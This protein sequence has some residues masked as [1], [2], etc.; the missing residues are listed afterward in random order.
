MLP[1]DN[2]SCDPEQEYFADGIVEDITMALSRFRWLF[3]IARNSS[4]TYKGRAVDVKQ[5]GRELGVRYVL[6]GSVR[7]AGNRMRIAGQ[8]IDAETGA[9]L[10]ADRFDG[11]LED[12]FDLQDH[13]TS[14]V[15][16]AIA[17]KLQRE[18][19]KRAKRK[20]TENLD[21]YDYYLRGLAS[22]RRWTKDANAEA[23]R[24]FC[25]A[26]EL[27]PGL[28]CAYGMAAWCYVRRKARGWMNERI[29][30]SAEAVRLARKA[31]HLGED[32]PVAL[33]MGGY[34]LAFVAH[35]FDD[36]AAFMDR[37]LAVNPN[38]GRSWTP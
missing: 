22:A 13:V 7:K 6:E 14:S 15:V 5:V 28:A 3:V 33:C 27:D 12:M 17:P 23:L 16:G 18:E 4:F 11:A 8:L 37:G 38:L 2:L 26:I 20:P 31:V 30:E 21:A 29:Q 1:F 24:L 32:D 34:A 35:E 9:H 19:I 36:A 10:W 25:K